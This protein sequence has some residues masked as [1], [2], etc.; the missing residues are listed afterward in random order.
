M[1][2]RHLAGISHTYLWAFIV[3]AFAAKASYLEEKHHFANDFI[4]KRS[5][6]FPMHL[7]KMASEYLQ[8][9]SDFLVGPRD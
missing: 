2:F 4:G 8:Q 6:H 3:L 7:Q 5:G 9:E 1:P